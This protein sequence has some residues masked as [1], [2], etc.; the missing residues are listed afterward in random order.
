MDNYINRRN[1]W[2]GFRKGGRWEEGVSSG[3][4]SEE[5]GVARGKGLEA[6]RTSDGVLGVKDC[7]PG[8][9]K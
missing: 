5:P 6:S 2:V 4:A 9:E 1:V 8:P 3:G 7:T